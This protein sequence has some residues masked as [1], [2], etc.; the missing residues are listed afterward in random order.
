L[1]ATKGNSSEKNNDNFNAR[2]PFLFNAYGG[3]TAIERWQQYLRG[4]KEKKEILQKLDTLDKK[5]ETCLLSTQEDG[6]KK[7]ITSYYKSLF[8]P[9]DESNTAMNRLGVMV[10]K[11]FSE[12]FTQKGHQLLGLKINFH[13]SLDFF[14]QSDQQKK[15]YRLAKL[16]NEDG[17][18]YNIVRYKHATGSSGGELGELFS[19]QKWNGSKKCI[20]LAIDLL[21]LWIWGLLGC[22]GS[23]KTQRQRYIRNDVMLAGPGTLFPII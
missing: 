2:W 15:K 19:S 6:L 22:R 10:M 18:L 4:W 16:L 7:H 9:A 13:K 21:Y 12:N 20:S 8:G 1:H 3:D 17:I 11:G 5:A 23:I 14:W